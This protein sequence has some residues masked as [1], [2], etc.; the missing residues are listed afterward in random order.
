MQAIGTC[1]NCKREDAPI[2]I[3]EI[4]KDNEFR[5][6]CLACGAPSQGFLVLRTEVQ[7]KAATS[8]V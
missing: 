3:L 6:Q 7:A 5:G 1:P 4:G 2:Q 8:S